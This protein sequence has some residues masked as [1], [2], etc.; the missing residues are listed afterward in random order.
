[1]VGSV[2]RSVGIRNL[3]TVFFTSIALSAASLGPVTAGNTEVAHAGPSVFVSKGVFRGGRDWLGRARE[4]VIEADL[5]TKLRRLHEIIGFDL[6][7][8]RIYGLVPRLILHSLPKDIHQV[9]QPNLRKILFMKTALPLILDVNEKILADRARVQ[10]LQK[11]LAFGQSLSGTELSWL[12]SKSAEYGF[13]A[14]NKNLN[15]LN[16][17]NLLRRL[18]ILPPSLALAQ[19]AEESGW[20]T[21]RFAREGNALFGQR[22]WKGSDGLVPEKRSEGET[23]RV[24]AFKNLLE[25]VWAYAFNLNTHRA[26]KNF[27]LV[28]EN[29][30]Y[31]GEALAGSRLI[32]TLTPYS[33]RG[34][35][36][37]Q[38]IKDLIRIN[39]LHQFNSSTLRHLLPSLEGSRSGV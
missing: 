35:E 14:V 31:S 38:S 18:D 19:A 33:E 13:G 15:K 9:S 37:V 12:K 28:R 22:T 6:G 32:E 24:R 26:Y 27:R 29:L 10:R 39:S 2:G 36:Y 21:S 20:G 23:F 3:L 30:R 17:K 8:V 4:G 34:D 7:E 25:S 1:M 16:F 11:Q 5:V